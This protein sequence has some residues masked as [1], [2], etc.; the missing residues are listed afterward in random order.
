[1]KNKFTANNL[2]ICLGVLLIAAALG[3]SGGNLLANCH[4][5]S[6][7]ANATATLQASITNEVA[8]AP[9]ASDVPL[10]MSHP[11]MTMPTTPVDGTAYIGI[12]AINALDLSLPVAADWSDTALKNSPCRYTGSAYTDDLVIAGHN[13]AAHFGTLSKLACDDELTFTDMDGNLFN[14]RV[15]EVEILPSTAIDEMCAG[16]WPLTLFTCTVGGQNRLAIRCDKM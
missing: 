1:M 3:L 7:A 8:D 11:E 12:L 10:Y 16:E 14:Y 2:L 4:A 15:G 9:A 6:T 13:Y 5:A